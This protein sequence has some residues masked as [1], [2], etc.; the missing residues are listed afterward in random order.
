M[1]RGNLRL[2]AARF[3]H[4]CRGVNLDCLCR[5]PLW[6][7]GVDYNHGTGHGVGCYLNVHEG[8]NGFR[9]KITKGG[10][11]AVLEAGMVTS[12]EPGLYLEGRFGIRHE[13]LI[14][15]CKGEKNEYG[16]FMFFDTL[17]MVPFD[18]DG[19]EISQMSEREKGLLNAYHKQVYQTIAPY[20][21]REER[22]WLAGAT[23]A[24]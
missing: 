20:L 15:C 13:N 19:I 11:S 12:N 17:T 22:E 23:R 1:L 8:P 2:A 16:Q 24:I 7:E 9:W 21:S 4:G 6:E 18:L 3:L 5:E 10:D 14:L